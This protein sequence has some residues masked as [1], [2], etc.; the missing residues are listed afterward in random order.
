MQGKKR[1][2]SDYRSQTPVARVLLLGR[3]VSPAAAFAKESAPTSPLS[4]DVPY[5]L[6]SIF[7]TPPKPSVLE[8]QA[9]APSPAT[10]FFVTK[11]Q[12]TRAG[13]RAR[14]TLRVWLGC[15]CLLGSLMFAA[16]QSPV[17]VSGDLKAASV[18]N[19]IR[20][21]SWPTSAFSSAK[22]PL[23]IGIVGTDPFGKQL[24]ELVAGEVVHN[25]SLIV[26]RLRADEDLRLCHAVFVAESEREH[27]PALLLQLKGNPVLTVSTLNGFA[28][29]GGMINLL[30]TGAETKLEINQAGAEKANLQISGKLLSLATIVPSP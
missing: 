10:V 18:L 24:D 3:V 20:F 25:R 9:A 11:P 26:K 19:C 16:A 29:Q 30:Q 2:K 23:V 17:A 28:Q 15:F 6:V 13:H 4:D 5:P 1:S 14:L 21:T 27:L 22:A 7:A 8:T 12:I